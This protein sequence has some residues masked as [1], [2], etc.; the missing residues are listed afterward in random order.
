MEIHPPGLW[1]L[2][3]ASPYS[4]F[5][6]TVVSIPVE[7]GHGPRLCLHS[8][9]FF[10]VALSCGVCSANLWIIYADMGVI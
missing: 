5:V 9:I 4:A 2:W 6:H 1:A 7:E 8:C 10:H 3:C